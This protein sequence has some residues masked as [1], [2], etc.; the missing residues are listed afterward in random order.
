VYDLS[1]VH[2][3][4]VH[5]AARRLYLRLFT[6]LSCRRARRVIAISDSTARDLA[7]TFGLPRDK[8]DLATGAHDPAAFRPLPKAQVEAFR[9][10]MGLPERFWL[11]VGT[12][13]PRKNLPTLLRAYAALPPDARI[14]LVLAGAKGWDYAAIFATLEQLGLGDAVRFPGFIP[15]ETLPLW[16]NSAETF[17]YPS[18]FEGFGLPVLEALACG[19]PAIISDASSLPEAGGEAAL[20]VS[21][22]DAEAWAAALHRAHHDAAWR[23][24]ARARGLD[25]AARFSWAQTARHTVTSYHRALGLTPAVETQ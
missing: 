1:F 10:R 24:E 7:A 8:I 6:A 9:A 19:T 25:H 15:A 23:A 2:Y 5:S 13:E 22:L 12:L 11:F 20:K 14:P 3:P 18:I 17:I 16:Y 21:P 4:G